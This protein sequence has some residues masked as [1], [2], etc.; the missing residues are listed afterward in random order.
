[1]MVSKKSLKLFSTIKYIH[2]HKHVHKNISFNQNH[3]TNENKLSKISIKHSSC[4]LVRSR[5]FFTERTVC[6]TSTQMAL[7]VCSPPQGR[8]VY[9]HTDME[10]GL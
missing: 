8:P 2:I 1:M 10:Q 4:C 7:C 3:K 5:Q 9:E 6:P